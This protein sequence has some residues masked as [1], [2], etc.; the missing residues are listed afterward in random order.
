MKINTFPPHISYRVMWSLIKQQ[1]ILP[2]LDFAQLDY[3]DLGMR[4]RDAT[5]DAVTVDA[6]HAIAKVSAFVRGS[7]E[8]SRVST[9]D[10]LTPPP[11]YVLPSAQST[12]WGSNAQPSRLTKLE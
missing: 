4:H 11:I 6:A 12:A 8:L 1:L 9:D 2:Y 7:S 5:G 10:I 3:Y